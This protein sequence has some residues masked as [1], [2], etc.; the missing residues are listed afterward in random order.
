MNIVARL[1]DAMSKIMSQDPVL[2]W[3][4]LCYN[5]RSLEF[6]NLLGGELRRFLY[7]EAPTSPGYYHVATVLQHLMGVSRNIDDFF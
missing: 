4:F 7:Y 6:D 2:A 3:N 1:D 5:S